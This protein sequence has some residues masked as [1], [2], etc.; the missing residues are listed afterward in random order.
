VDRF[1]DSAPIAAS[2]RR[3][4]GADLADFVRWYGERPVEEIDVRVLSEWIAH[5]GSRRGGRLSQTTIARKVAAL[6]SF[7]RF[8]LGPAHVPDAPFSA[9]AGRRLPDAPRVEEVER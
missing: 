5:L 1:L 9:R 3:G 4:Y 2:T 6:R 7:V 8:T